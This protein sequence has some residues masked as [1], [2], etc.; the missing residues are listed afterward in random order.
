MYY[1]YFKLPLRALLTL[2]ILPSVID[3]S[4]GSQIQ[5]P[6]GVNELSNW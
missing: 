2:V 3:E 1:V 5:N 4:P 6:R